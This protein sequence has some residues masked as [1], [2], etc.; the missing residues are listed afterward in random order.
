MEVLQKTIYAIEKVIER[1]FKLSSWMLIALILIMCYEVIARYVLHNP[2]VWSQEL[3]YFIT[4]F[5]I[6]MAIAYTLQVK[7][8]VTIDIFYN[9]FSRKGKLIVNILFTLFFFIP[10]W[11]M[12]LQAMLPSFLHA[13]ET[14]ER[15][16]Y[17]NW[18]PVIWPFRL[19]ILAGTVLLF[20][21]ALVDLVKNTT[22]L[23][24]GEVFK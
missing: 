4:S 11:F 9:R 20:V 13:F 15:S 19:W 2:T 10:V 3:S 6:M 17:G 24:K 23:F 16:S 8:H 22:N 18:L 7:E 12:L 5:V 21:Q 14:G 1:V